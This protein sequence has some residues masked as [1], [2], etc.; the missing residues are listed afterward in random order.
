MEPIPL[1]IEIYLEVFLVLRVVL[2]RKFYMYVK[3]GEFGS[4]ID[5]ACIVPIDRR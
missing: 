3:Q 1:D 2:L 5:V 4:L